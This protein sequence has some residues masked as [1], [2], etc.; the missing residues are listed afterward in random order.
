MS[1]ISGSSGACIFPVGGI[2]DP[3]ESILDLPVTPDE[4]QDVPGRGFLGGEAGHPEDALLAGSSGFLV[5]SEPIDAKNLFKVGEVGVSRKLG[6]DPDGLDGGPA[7]SREGGL[8][9][10]GKKPRCRGGRSR[11]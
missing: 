1:P 2:P 5:P 11:L 7:M 10:R 4:V 6:G 8:M 9:G 3:V